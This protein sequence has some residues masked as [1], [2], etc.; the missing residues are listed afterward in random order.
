MYFRMP[1]GLAVATLVFLGLTARAADDAWMMGVAGVKI[2]PEKP[3]VLAGYAARTKPFEK[4]TQDIYAKALALQDAAGQRAVLVTFDI[5][6]LPADVASQ[7]RERIA[8]QSKLDP[9][10]IL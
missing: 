1:L 8:Q 4:V 6:I 2:T 5:C 3:V 7:M 9:A 10:A